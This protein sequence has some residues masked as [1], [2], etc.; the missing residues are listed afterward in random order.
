MVGSISLTNCN[1]TTFQFSLNYT[2]LKNVLLGN[3]RSVTKLN[4]AIQVNPIQFEILKSFIS[5]IENGKNQCGY[6]L[7]NK[8]NFCTSCI[9]HNVVPKRG[10]QTILNIKFCIERTSDRELQVIIEHFLRKT[11]DE[12]KLN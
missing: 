2:K 1:Y 7:I 5:F 4:M 10:E 8:G 3:G 6:I 9:N 11:E 12:I